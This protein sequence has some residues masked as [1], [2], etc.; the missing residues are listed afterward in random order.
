[1]VV[2]SPNIIELEVFAAFFGFHFLLTRVLNV[3][4]H[5]NVSSDLVLST[6]EFD[7]SGS[8][9]ALGGSDIR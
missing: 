6:V 8:Y 7:H 2:R 4:T 9:L 5:F 3:R 1:M